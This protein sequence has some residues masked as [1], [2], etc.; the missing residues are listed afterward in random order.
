MKIKD[1]VVNLKTAQLLNK[2][3][4]D[5]PTVFYWIYV[6]REWTIALRM[7]R[8]FLC[9]MPR[10]DSRTWDISAI[11]ES[12]P[13]PTAEELL[14]NLPHEHGIMRFDGIFQEVIPYS[15]HR[16]Y[17]DKHAA[18]VLAEMWLEECGTI[19]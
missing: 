18:S 16:E 5:T 12:I 6:A 15:P 7:D 14:Y 9:K 3:G 13:A 2:H 17:H 4:W 11:N 8:T 10:G 1:I 19:E